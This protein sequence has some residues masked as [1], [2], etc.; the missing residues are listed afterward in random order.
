MPRPV[1]PSEPYVNGNVFHGFRE[2]A[3]DVW[4][5]QG[6]GEIEARLPDDAHADVVENIV[7]PVS[8]Y[9]VRHAIAWHRA[10]WE[11]PA[12]RN[13]ADFCHFIDR[14]VELGFGRFKRA[15]L[16]FATPEVLLSRASELWRSQHT[17]GTLDA[18]WEGEGAKMTLRD[19][20]YV[21][22][23]VSARLQAEAFRKIASLSRTRVARERHGVQGDALV[24]HLVW[25]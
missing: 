19:H 9:P 8:W 14:S 16:A 10:A 15:L 7:L 24:V 11:G 5:K 21:A 18:Q 22:S 4:D 1:A 17:H 2:A 12:R 25:R 20:P 13:D 6:L 3:L 23:P